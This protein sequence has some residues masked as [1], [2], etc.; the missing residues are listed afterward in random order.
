[1]TQVLRT[2]AR[3]SPSSDGQLSLSPARQ[4]KAHWARHLFSLPVRQQVEQAAVPQNQLPV[5]KVKNGFIGYPVSGCGWEVGGR[6]EDPAPNISMEAS[7]RWC[8]FLVAPNPVFRPE[9]LH[10]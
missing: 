8:Q 9:N 4:A 2:Q 7:G 10:T 6:S 1:M 3:T 5:L